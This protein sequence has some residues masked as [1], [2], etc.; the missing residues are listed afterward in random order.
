[1]ERIDTVK[2]LMG[3][4]TEKDAKALRIKRLEERLALMKAA[5]LRSEDTDRTAYKAAD[6]AIVALEREIWAE[7][8]SED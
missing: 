1:M 4:S 8:V 7:R 3:R 6:K 2:T 5:R